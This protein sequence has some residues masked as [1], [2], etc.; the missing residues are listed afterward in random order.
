MAGRDV[1]GVAVG[2]D[3]HQANLDT[4]GVDEGGWFDIGP[5]HRF[6]GLAIHDIR[7]QKGKV[8]LGGARLESAA[9]I[10]AGNHG[11]R[12]G[13][14]GAEI[15]FVIADGGR[16]VAQ[17]IVVAHH[18]GTLGHVGLQRAQEHV[19]RVEEHHRASAAR[20]RLA[21]ILHV[22]CQPGQSLDVSV[23]IARAHHREDYL[24]RRRRV[25]A[26]GEGQPGDKGKKDAHSRVKYDRAIA[27]GF[28]F[29]RR[30][31]TFALSSPLCVPYQSC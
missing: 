18:R 21:Q 25:R 4:C 27:R 8:G 31:Q 2:D 5:G 23:Q 24:G 15:E 16:A 26:G 6:A 20:S 17:G 13:P 19:A 29:S 12:R 28:E 1:C 22:A 11:P 9:R 14:D 10:V 3:A 7:R 30:V